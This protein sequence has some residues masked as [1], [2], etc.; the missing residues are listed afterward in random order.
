MGRG[1]DGQKYVRNGRGE[2]VASVH[3]RATGDGGQI[4]AILVCM[5]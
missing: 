5:Y 2:V 3:K 1:L 4:F